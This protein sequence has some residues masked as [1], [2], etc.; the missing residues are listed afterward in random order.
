MNITIIK[1]HHKIVP[2]S[3]RRNTSRHARI[4]LFPKDY[5]V[6]DDF[7][8]RWGNKRTNREYVNQLRIQVL[9]Q[10]VKQYNISDVSKIQWSSKAGCA[11]GCSPGFIVHEDVAVV[12]HDI[13]VEIELK[14]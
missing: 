12:N 9:P 3:E 1:S 8:K 4:H 6:L 10:I 7:E 2:A 11:C 14:Q 13:F 5:N